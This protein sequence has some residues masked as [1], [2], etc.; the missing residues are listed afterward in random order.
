MGRPSLTSGIYFHAL[1]VGNFEGIDS[2]QEALGV[3]AHLEPWISELP[4]EAAL[5]SAP[6]ARTSARSQ[7]GGRTRYC[8]LA[9]G[10]RKRN[11][12]PE[13]ADFWLGNRG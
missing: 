10:Q 12:R 7:K 1:L 2:E 9:G 4:A 8:V 6:Q 11:P 5:S 13:A 3:G